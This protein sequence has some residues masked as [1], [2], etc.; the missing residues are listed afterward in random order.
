M[1]TEWKLGVLADLARV[2]VLSDAPENELSIRAKEGDL[3]SIKLLVEKNKLATIDFINRQERLTKN[4]A[5][6]YAV[7]EGHLDIVKYLVE[8]GAQTDKQDHLDR[9]SLHYAAM[10]GHLD[11][12]KYLVESGANIL[13][14]DIT[15]N[16]PLDYVSEARHIK[17]TENNKQFAQ[18]I[19]A[20]LKTA[21]KDLNEKTSN[22]KQ[23]LQENKSSDE[24]QPIP[25]SSSTGFT[26]N[27][28]IF[29]KYQ[30]V[31]NETTSSGIFDSLGNKS[32]SPS[33][34]IQITESPNNF[35]AKKDDKNK[36]GNDNGRS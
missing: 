4:T 17:Q 10:E 31:N 7:M 33:P 21:E 15:G 20:Y 1:T 2:M 12:V 28:D 9:I 24:K 5:L 29:V 35:D 13:A 34:V 19:A 32:R 23:N 16:K 22:S 3:D 8:N 26:D 36:D 25:A 27:T 11:I 6:D 30:S 18:E 14:Q